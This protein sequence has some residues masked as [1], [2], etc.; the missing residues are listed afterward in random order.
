MKI[1]NSVVYF[2]NPNKLP[3]ED[4]NYYAIYDYTAE[5]VIYMGANTK[6]AIIKDITNNYQKYGRRIRCYARKTQ[7]QRGKTGRY[8][9]TIKSPC[10]NTIKRIKNKYDLKRS[11]RW[12]IVY[13]RFVRIVDTETGEVI[14]EWNKE[15]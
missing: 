12:S 15:N 7:A 5:G 9:V 1:G 14:G 2:S 6:D 11:V 8:E 3:L 13:G 10:Y 4:C